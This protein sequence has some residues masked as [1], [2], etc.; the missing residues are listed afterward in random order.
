EDDPA[1]WV[2]G[3]LGSDPERDRGTTFHSGVRADALRVAGEGTYFYSTAGSVK[4]LDLFMRDE[5]PP[6]VRAVLAEG[7]QRNALSGV[8]VGDGCVDT[9]DCGGG[10]TCMARAAARGGGLACNTC[11]LPNDQGGTW[12]CRSN[13][14]CCGGL[15]CCVDCGAKSGTCLA[16][17]DPCET[18]IAN[19][20]H[21]NPMSDT[22]DAESCLPDS[23]CYSD[24]CPGRCGEDN[25]SGCG[26]PD[27][28]WAAGCDWVQS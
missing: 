25:C 26:R 19:T 13:S 21:W 20:G 23:E 12:A 1:E 14:D 10:Q 2:V 3:S 22:C 27:E 9:D 11:I 7:K 18:C 4:Y 5:P 16:D 17:E 15:V 8:S 28:C 6:K 24:A